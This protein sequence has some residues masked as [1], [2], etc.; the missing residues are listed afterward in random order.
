MQTQMAAMQAQQLDT[1]Q[2]LM[3]L[4]SE[5]QATRTQ[6]DAVSATSTSSNNPEHAAGFFSLS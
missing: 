2:L 1:H 5:L 3:L 6:E 4:R